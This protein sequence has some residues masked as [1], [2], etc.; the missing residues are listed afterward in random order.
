MQ[1]IKSEMALLGLAMLISDRRANAEI[2][3]TE[4]MLDSIQETSELQVRATQLKDAI[5]LGLNFTAQYLG[6]GADAGGSIELGATWAEL[7]ISPQELTALSGM[8]D[9]GQLSL[10]SLLWYLEKGGKLPPDVTAYEELKRIKTEAQDTTLNP[11]PPPTIS[12]L[13]PNS[14]PADITRMT[15]PQGGMGGTPNDQTKQAA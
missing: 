8:V 3:A 13:N 14:S 9:L 2:T 12:P 5:E 4:K 10:E 11:P 6:L 1:N 7:I 15:K